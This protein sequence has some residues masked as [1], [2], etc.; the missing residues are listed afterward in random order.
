MIPDSYF[1]GT[2]G[3]HRKQPA[4]FPSLPFPSLCIIPW[5]ACTA[6]GVVANCYQ[7]DGTRAAGQ[8]TRSANAR[9][10]QLM[11]ARPTHQTAPHPTG[12]QPNQ[13]GDATR[14]CG[15]GQEENT[16]IRRQFLRAIP[17]LSPRDR[18]GGV[19][20]CRSAPC[21]CFLLLFF[22]TV[23]TTKNSGAPGGGWN[24]HRFR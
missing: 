22:F 15:M 20:A 2:E 7:V 12:D 6:H 23:L 9:A 14:A 4:A 8:V 21:D 17:P 16:V 11:R 18:R 10:M 24:G 5:R 1:I 19:D 13:L 3:I